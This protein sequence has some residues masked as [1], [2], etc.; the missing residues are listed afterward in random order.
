M[1]WVA[2]LNPT[3][4]GAWGNRAAAR[5]TREYRGSRCGG[6]YGGET[7]GIGDRGRIQSQ[8]TGTGRDKGIARKDHTLVGSTGRESGTLVGGSKSGIGS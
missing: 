4:E 2:G 1:R 3:C 7:N 6:L 8:A 5:G